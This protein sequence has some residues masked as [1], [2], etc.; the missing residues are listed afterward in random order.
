MDKYLKYKITTKKAGL[1]HQSYN[2][3]TLFAEAYLTNRIPVIS[4]IHLYG[5]HNFDKPLFSDL[6]KYYEY[7]ETKIMGKPQKYCFEDDLA[8]SPIQF[9][10]DGKMPQSANYVEKIFPSN[11]GCSWKFL[12]SPFDI[13]YSVTLSYRDEIYQLA[14]QISKA[15]GD[16]YACVHVRRGDVLK[17]FSKN[18][19]LFFDTRPKNILKVLIQNSSPEKVYIMTNE[20]QSFFNFKESKF[21]FYLSRHF[22][23]IDRFRKEDNYYLFCI[24]NLI[25]EN[26]KLRISTFNDPNPLYHDCL[27]NLHF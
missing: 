11:E 23:G 13:Y 5:K 25:M 9:K 26:A 14:N 7:S 16:N 27:S 6:S 10:Y 3:K 12:S 17:L 21:Q 19:P 20:N 22:P 15:L 4:K 1:K 24:E 2:I 8:I 18:W